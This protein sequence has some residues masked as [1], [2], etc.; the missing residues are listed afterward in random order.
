M[1]S[2]ST[3]S[4]DTYTASYSDSGTKSGAALNP[5]TT[6]DN[7]YFVGSYSHTGSQTVTTTCSFTMVSSYF[8]LLT[9][10]TVTTTTTFS[11]STSYSATDSSD[12]DDSDTDTLDSD[13]DD[14]SLTCT[15]SSMTSAGGVS[16]LTFGTSSSAWSMNE[17]ESPT[18]GSSDDDTWG[19][20]TITFQ[21]TGGSPSVDSA[22]YN[23]TYNNSLSAGI[24]TVPAAGS[25]WILKVQE[26]EGAV[27]T[28]GSSGSGSSSSSSS[29][30]GASSSGSLGLS[31]SS[32]S[33]SSSSGSSTSSSSSNS[34]SAGAAA[35]NG[36]SPAPGP[37]SGGMMVAA[38]AVTIPSAAVGQA[39]PG[40][41][42]LA[43]ATS[44]ITTATQSGGSQFIAFA[45]APSEPGFTASASTEQ[46][47]GGGVMDSIYRFVYTGD[48]N[49]SDEQ[50][51]AALEAAGK[52]YT[53]L[54][55]I[56][57]EALDT[58]GS[59][60]G[61]AG[62]VAHFTN[63]ALYLMEGDTA[64]AAQSGLSAASALT[65]GAANCGNKANKA[66]KIAAK[67]VQVAQAVNQGVQAADNIQEAI[68]AFND[69]DYLTFAQQLGFAAPNAAGAV[70][71]PSPGTWRLL[72]RGD[73]NPDSRRQQ[74]N[75]G[76][77]T[78]RLGVN[79]SRRRPRR[80][81]GPSSGRRNVRELPAAPRPLRERPDDSH[82]SRAPVLGKRPRLGRRAAARGWR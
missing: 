74:A 45:A 32:S 29:S 11:A 64:Q 14:G 78:W 34:S 50:Y 72:R 79:G 66:I 28:I 10:L 26:F 31:S 58:I 30:S 40:A 75:R 60:T 80:R 51:N 21:E 49:A 77:P 39:A 17:S 73:A 16:A 54:A 5:P 22:S 76:V 1:S 44:G 4:S 35:A 56:A 68:A 65:G 69:S 42:T 48:A 41:V 81:A 25:E 46:G 13:T 57:H 6:S 8:N 37:F 67:T 53:Q 33:S 3:S 23:A 12:D 59:F 63:A 43:A 36:A 52:V 55:P 70:R 20:G 9:G 18:A 62:S 7:P 61:P 24:V 47:G 15:F 82:D 38:G 27:G 2:S 71:G 19:N